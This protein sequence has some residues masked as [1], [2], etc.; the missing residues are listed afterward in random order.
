MIAP[1]IL[2]QPP[3]VE[4]ANISKSYGPVRANKDISLSIRSGRIKALLGE[5]GAG[6]ST[7]MSILSGLVR[8]DA[9]E[10]RVDGAPM[11]LSHP[12]D[13]LEAGIGMVYQHF[14]LINAMTVAENI[15][16]G[17]PGSARISPKAMRAEV[18][19]LSQRYKL[20]VDPD[21]L[22]DGLSMGER[23]RVEILKLL[24]RRA[25][26]LILDEPTAV[27]SPLE[28]E[29]LF[30]A[31]RSMAEQGAAIVF[32]SHKLQEVLEIADEVSIL[33]AGQVVDEFTRN[34]V[35]DQATLASRM[36][37]RELARMEPAR[38]LAPFDE[39]LDVER[40]SGNGLDQIS[41]SL[42]RG[43][44]LAVV[45]VA[46]NGQNALA[47]TLAGLS[48]PVSGSVRVL[49]APW[50]EYFRRARTEGGVVY[51]PED[52]RG[53]AT[54]PELPLA[55]NF[56]LTTRALFSGAFCLNRAAA[57]EAT[58]RIIWEH[59]VRPD[60]PAIR[61]RVLSGGNLQKLVIGREF[62]R[63]PALIIAENPTQGLDV[64]AAGEVWS[65]LLEAR[66]S[67]GILLITNDLNEAL[68]LADRI[69]VMYRG[70]FMALF[71]RDNAEQVG[72]IGLWMAGINP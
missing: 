47:E 71:D 60:N 62:Y 57:L 38:R 48:R 69:A 15:F 7:L 33:R 70:R 64:A 5:N 31:L 18:A 49:N 34:T 55:D 39:V 19:R 23:Q 11:A 52:R 4:L 63:K 42:R 1:E 68:A 22:I 32:I 8:P 17:Q 59:D 50:E 20:A 58:R 24:Y 21:A 53:L 37:G 35:P 28:T 27:L 14:M 29:Q 46:G 3:V 12:K 66:S 45:G 51:I 56:L 26:V 9:G 72:R 6:K 44:I 30:T 40:L 16:L 2:V 10:I 25:R 61:A 13:A 67:A 54:C 65:R 36:I 41:F 43:E